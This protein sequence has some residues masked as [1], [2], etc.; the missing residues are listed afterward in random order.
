MT[1]KNIIEQVEKVFG[2][3]S[4]QYMYRLV[5]DALNEISAKKQHKT[6]DTITDL[7]VKQRAYSLSDS[8][9]DI[10]RVEIKDTNGRYVMIPKLADSHKL[11][12]GDTDDS[13]DSLV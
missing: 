7:K 9:I 5:N 10:T 6:A 4:E 13:D 12:K 11:L 8:V 1:V 2:R 3:Q